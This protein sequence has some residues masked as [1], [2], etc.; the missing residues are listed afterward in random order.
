M[1]WAA[2]LRA[3]NGA[4]LSHETAAELVGL[5]DR[6]SAKI[7]VTVPHRRTP[8]R[9]PGVVV[10]RSVRAAASR[11]PSRMPPQTTVEDTVVDLTQTA[12]SIDD[13]M[14]WLARA[15]GER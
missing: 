3:G 11:H 2:V 7:H 1:M 5:T 10:H 14:G 9:I 15:I 13:A 6:P 8:A 12:R 4:V